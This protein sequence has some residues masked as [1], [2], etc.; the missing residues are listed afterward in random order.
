MNDC[1]VVSDKA[2]LDDVVVEFQNELLLFLVPELIQQIEKVV[3]IHLAGIQC[4]TRRHVGKSNDFHSVLDNR[5]IVHCAFHISA[6][7]D[8]KID[9]HASRLHRFRHVSRDNDRSLAAE[10]LCRSNHDI[11]LRAILFHYF[12]LLF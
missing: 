11:G 4:Y 7:I 5:F 2:A 1:P 10:H 8:R 12:A 9:D 6:G 3:G